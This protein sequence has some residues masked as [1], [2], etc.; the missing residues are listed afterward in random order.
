[1]I[2][3]NLLAVE[4]NRP[5]RR[6]GFDLGQR[7]T[8]VC[9]VIF[10]AVLAGVVWQALAVRGEA[11]RLREQVRLVDEEL[12][13]MV[14]VVGQRN[15]FEDR[16]AELARRVALI[17]ELRDGQGGP[18]RMIDQVSR[19]LPQGVWLTELRQEGAVITIQGRATSLTGLSDLV[20][21]M[22]R[23]GHFALPVAIIDSQLE[24]QTLGE[25]VRFE[26]R[27]EFMLPSS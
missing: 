23:S 12:A 27:A 11:A 3:I 9:V 19:A 4:R 17:E 21:G 22:E 13:T 6:I 15:E 16:S 5:K 25:V 10:V 8:L 1:M 2:R 20:V 18:V 26:L 24:V 7:V 14:D